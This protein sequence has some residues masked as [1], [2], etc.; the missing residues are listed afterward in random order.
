MPA[1]LPLEFISN[2]VIDI[3]V[4]PGKKDSAPDRWDVDALEIDD[5]VL[6][7]TGR[8]TFT[9]PPKRYRVGGVALFTCTEGSVATL[10]QAVLAD[11]VRGPAASILYTFLR[12][13]LNTVAGIVAEHERFPGTAPVAPH[14]LRWDEGNWQV[15]PAAE[16]RDGGLVV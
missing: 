13:H 10:D 16:P 8:L 1:P 4:D 5:F 14:L 15:R 9:R 6:F 12:G 2:S 3:H 11:F 7:V